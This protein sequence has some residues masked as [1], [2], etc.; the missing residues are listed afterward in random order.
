[1]QK[2][3]FMSYSAKS[4]VFSSSLDVLLRM[5]HEKQLCFAIGMLKPTSSAATAVRWIGP[6]LCGESSCR[7]PSAIIAGFRSLSYCAEGLP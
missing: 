5:K 6:R 1:M 4:R 3:N 7:G 2:V